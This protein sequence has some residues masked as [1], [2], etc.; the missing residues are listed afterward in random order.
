MAVNEPIAY[1]ATTD[2]FVK[3][4]FFKSVLLALVLTSSLK[5][6]M[7]PQAFSASIAKAKWLRCD[8]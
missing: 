7:A 5:D 2:L 8:V 1:I 3:I 4:F 6:R